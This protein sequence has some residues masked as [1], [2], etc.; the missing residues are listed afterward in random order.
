MT[1]IGI[2][3]PKGVSPDSSPASSRVR[4]MLGRIEYEGYLAGVI[5][6]MA[7]VLT[8]TVGSAFWGS[9]NLSGLLLDVAIDTVPAIGMTLVI[10]TGGIDVSIGSLVSVVAVVIG[11]SFEAHLP[12]VLVLLIGIVVG[13]GGGLVNG[14]IV[15]WGRVPPIIVTLGTL[16]VFEAITYQLLGGVWI[17]TIPAEL[18]QVVVLDRLGPVPYSFIVAVALVAVFSYIMARRPIGLKIYATGDNPEAARTAGLPIRRIQLF[19]YA[20]LGGLTAIAALMT[21]GQ[22]PLVMPTTGQDFELTVIAAAVVGGTNILGG[23]GKVIGGLLG[24]L[25]VEMVEDAAILYHVNSFY[26]QIVLGAM[27]V[28]G[29]AIGVARRRAR[30]GAKAER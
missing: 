10:V 24:A 26:Q 5:V 3:L 21:V 1:D 8:F 18:T 15:A 4:H 11:L 19:V 9:T 16:S 29:V 13:I 27:I 25:L 20:L 6:V 12:F 7:I 23:E 28:A 14:A 17:S 30:L 2:A 22:S